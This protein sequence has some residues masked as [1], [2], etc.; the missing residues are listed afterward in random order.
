MAGKP[1][2]ACGL[3]RK[4][5]R[6]PRISPHG[7]AWISPWKQSIRASE[8]IHLV[9]WAS[10]MSIK[11]DA[12]TRASCHDVKILTTE[13]HCNGSKPSR[14]RTKRQHSRGREDS[15]FSST[16]TIRFNE[17]LDQSKWK[18]PETLDENHTGRFHYNCQSTHTLSH[19]LTLSLSHTL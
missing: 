17:I 5:M 3:K 8:L 9:T 15:R 2:F 4:E 18:P 13:M 19:T 10:K 1:V 11:N 14:G 6:S 7:G 12:F 16:T